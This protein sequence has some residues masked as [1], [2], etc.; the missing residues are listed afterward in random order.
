MIKVPNNG[1]IIVLH[2][3]KK[4]AEGKLYKIAENEKMIEAYLGENAKVV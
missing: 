2:H 1:P 4:I 3:G